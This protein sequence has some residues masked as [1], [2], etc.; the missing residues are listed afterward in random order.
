MN[1]EQENALAT[2]VN[3]SGFPFQWKVEDLVNSTTKD[4]HWR[5]ESSEHG[6]KDV[7]TNQTGF[8]DIV[9]SNENY[10]Y[11]LIVECKRPLGGQWVFLINKD[12]R[13]TDRIR[14]HW[15]DGC[16]PGTSGWHDFKFE[17]LALESSLCIIGGQNERTPMLE[18]LSGE[19]LQS[20][21]ALSCREQ[22]IRERGGAGS[23]R[24]Y[25]PRIVTAAQLKACYVDRSDIS[26]DGRIGATTMF[27]DLTYIRFRKSLANDLTE[28]ASPRNLTEENLNK[29]RTIMVVNV[30][31]L[32]ELIERLRAKVVNDFDFYPWDRYG[33]KPTPTKVD[34]N[35]SIFRGRS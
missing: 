24:I 32:L 15:N 29:E 26:L 9:L 34:I 30:H 12:A 2:L 27:D 5:V 31:H 35:H 13:P 8:I 28:D 18:R 10:I 22:T 7:H 14:C 21:Q 25:I 17:P 20:T 19:L 16:S 11:K 1:A 33:R 4:H 3:K 23:R 6:W